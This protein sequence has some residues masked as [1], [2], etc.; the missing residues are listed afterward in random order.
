MSGSTF[1]EELKRLRVKQD[2]SLRLVGEKVHSGKSHI[3]NLENGKATPDLRTATL[4]DDLLKAD[5]ALVRLAKADPKFQRLRV[6]QSVPFNVHSFTG[7]AAQLLAEGG[8]D[9]HRRGFVAGATG[10]AGLGV[11]APSLALES[12]RHGLMASM[13]EDRSQAGVDEW[14]QIIEDTGAD[15]LSTSPHDL[16]DPLMVD[17]VGSQNAIKATSNPTEKGELRRVG[18]ILSVYAAKTFSNLGL[19]RESRRW[20]RTAQQIAWGADNGTVLWVRGH[21]IVRSLYEQHSIDSILRLVEEAD[22]YL[23]NATAEELPEFMGGKA[24]A[25]AVAGRDGEAVATLHQA[26]EVYNQLPLSLTRV[27]GRESDRLWPE[28]RIAFTQSFVYSY[29]GHLK[30]ADAAQTRALELYAPDFRRGP[31]QI[32][33]QRALCMVKAGD[34]NG[35]TAYA[36]QVMQALPTGDHVRTIIDLAHTVYR[37]V[38][39][40]G[41]GLVAVADFREYLATPTKPELV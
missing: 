16:L 26:E 18:A 30:E 40:E 31:A 35:G 33:L 12:A 1:G 22:P 34:A 4:L 37:A 15:Y 25:L 39:E 17:V 20:W 19:T 5:G 10:V 9:M 2:L 21:E 29:L 32:K 3:W 36:Q 7:L 27:Q 6:A 23:T 14:N 41:R 38:P 11:L 13:I 24:Q 28:N 8:E